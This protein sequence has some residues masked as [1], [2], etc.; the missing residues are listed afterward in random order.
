M[1]TYGL[2]MNS[3]LW[4]RLHPVVETILPR[5]D[6]ER[7]L[8]VLDDAQSKPALRHAIESIAMIV[9]AYRQGYGTRFNKRAGVAEVLLI[10]FCLMAAGSLFN[11]AGLLV[12]GAVLAALSLRDVWLPWSIG[13]DTVIPPV[14]L[15]YLDSTMDAVCAA[16]SVVFAQTMAVFVSPA[17]VSSAQ[18]LV[19]IGAVCLP[20]LSLLRVV[21]RPMPEPARPK[22]WKGMSAEYVFMWTWRLN[23]LWMLV[24][25]LTLMANTSDIPNYWPDRMRGR[26]AGASF[27]LW[28]VVG[29]NA[30][31]RFDRIQ[32]LFEPWRKTK[33]RRWKEMLASKLTRG[34]Q[35]YWERVLV[36]FVMFGGLTLSAADAIWRWVSD[37]AGQWGV[38]IVAT[39]VVGVIASVVS[40]RYV[41][42]ANY[43]AAEALQ[44]EIDGL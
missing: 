21:L 5:A 4:K 22:E 37:N 26:I 1:K 35:G 12:L 3:R 10:G 36:E 23:V 44:D 34:Q 42:A 41:K 16:T 17:L 30:L 38:F 27:G 11:P 39:N 25:G 9:L 7:L 32:R 28:I 29:R 20:L 40:W 14:S 43:A 18:V 13:Y 8:T 6:R 33:L 2:E 15:Y 24:Y 31:Y 19:R